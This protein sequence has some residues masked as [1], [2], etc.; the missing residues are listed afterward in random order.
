MRYLH[1][2]F[3][4]LPIWIQ[5]LYAAPQSNPQS[6]DG[7]TNEV[8][9]GVDIDTVKGLAVIGISLTSW[10]LA[11][12]YMEGMLIMFHPTPSRRQLYEN[13]RDESFER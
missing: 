7:P 13:S 9:L 12:L 3:L 2:L 1:Y 8:N 5:L 6:H 4:L 11:Y 10:Y